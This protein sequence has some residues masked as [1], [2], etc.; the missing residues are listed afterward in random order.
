VPSA[1]RF[2][3]Q[4]GDRAGVAGFHHD[5]GLAEG[6]EVVAPVELLGVEPAC[7]FVASHNVPNAWP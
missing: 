5:R 4:P 1:G 6:R 3:D 2:A 7:A